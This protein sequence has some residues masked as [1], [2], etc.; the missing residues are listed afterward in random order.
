MYIRRRP[1][2]L[3]TKFILLLSLLLA[4]CASNKFSYLDAGG[5][6]HSASLSN[7]VELHSYDKNKFLLDWNKISYNDDSYYSKLGI[8]I[9][10]HDGD[11]DWKKVKAWGA[12]F[13]IVRV[14]FRG[15]KSGKINLDKKVHQNIKG[16]LA[17]GL[18][19]GAYF[20]SQAINQKE[21]L[22]EAETV[23]QELRNY[24]ITLPVVYD[25]ENIL[26]DEART[27]HVGSD[28]FTKNAVVFCEAV[29]AAG[30]RPMVY[31]NMIWETKKLNLDKLKDY[32]IWFADYEKIPQTPYRF[33]MWQYSCMGL[34]DGIT[35]PEKKDCLVDL[36]IMLIK[37]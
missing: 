29:K 12:D 36:N 6:E 19:V 32:G 18:E 17:A 26:N 25:P 31:M 2:I 22:E 37:K 28:T 33:S 8:D 24:N 34:V 14:G 1:I 10:H 4:S 27:D 9:S 5:G 23:I 11:I 30:Y 13:V 21:A 15:Y 35:I 7:K 16:A 20:F 3:S